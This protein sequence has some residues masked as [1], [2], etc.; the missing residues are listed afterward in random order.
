MKVKRDWE[1]A[2]RNLED[3]RLTQMSSCPARSRPCQKG[4]SPGRLTGLGLMSGALASR[5]PS[6]RLAL[7]G[8]NFYFCFCACTPPLPPPELLF[9][10]ARK[11]CALAADRPG[12]TVAAISSR[13]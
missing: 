10:L 12:V 6:G 8:R 7:H 1:S 13:I 4:F 11:N 5:P 2:S 3:F 9:S